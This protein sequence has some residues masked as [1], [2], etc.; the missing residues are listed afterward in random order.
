MKSIFCFSLEVQCEKCGKKDVRDVGR[1]LIYEKSYVNYNF[2][3]WMPDF[4][5]RLP[6]GWHEIEQVA[7]CGDCY[8]KIRESQL[9]AHQDFHEFIYGN[10]KTND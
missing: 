2:S 4:I 8:D 9:K 7:I 3:K 6:E 5:I 10:R 1:Y